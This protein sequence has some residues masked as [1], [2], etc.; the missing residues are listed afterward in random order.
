MEYSYPLTIDP[1][2]ILHPMPQERSH[3]FAPVRPYDKT[4]IGLYLV[5]IV[6][7]F[8]S[9]PKQVW[10]LFFV[11]L[12]SI[13]LFLALSSSFLFEWKVESFTWNDLGRIFIFA[14]ATNLSQGN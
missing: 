10:I 13:V 4:V 6:Q 12:A 5:Q 7:G 8:R 1:Y 2:K 11:S 14:V 3:L 9:I